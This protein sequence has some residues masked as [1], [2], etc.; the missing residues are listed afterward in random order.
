MYR[1]HL[2][3]DLR[4]SHVDTTVQLAG[5]VHRRRDHGGLVFIDLRDHSGLGQVV[6]HPEHPSFELA[7]TLR[8]EDVVRVDGTVRHRPEGTVND[9]LPSGAV[10]VEATALTVLNRSE[11]PPFEIDVE[12]PVHEDLRLEYRYLD[13]RHERLQ[14]NLA[15]RHR[16]VKRLRDLLDAKGF[17]EVETPSLVKGTPEGSREFLVPSR[18]HPGKFYVLPQSPQQFKQLLMVGGV[19]KYF[20]I[21]RCYR[22]EDQRGDR[23]PEFTQLDLEVAFTDDEEIMQLTEELLIDLTRAVVPGK[24]IQTVPFPR[25][26]WAEAMGRYGTD[27]PDLRFEM[28]FTDVSDWAADCG[29]K[30]FTDVAAAGGIVKALRVAGGGAMSRTQIDKLTEVAKAAGAKGL[31]YVVL[32]ADGTGPLAKNLTPEAVAALRKI[33]GAEDGDLLLFGAGR[34]LGEAVT[35]LGA[36]RLAVAEQQGL[37][38]KDALSYVWVTNFPLFE[39]GDD[40]SIGAGHHP[41]TCPM[42]A[43][44][45]R[46]ETDPLSVGS[47]TYDIVLN[48]VEVGGGSIRIHDRELQARVFRALKIDEAAQERRF[49]HMLRAFTYGAP[50]HGGIAWGVD[51]IVML[52]LD[53]PNIREVIA[54]PKNQRAQDLLMGAPS[55]LPAKDVAE[56]HIRVIEEE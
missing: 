28:A 45:D 55:E 52:F 15:V 46:L 18:L 36:V 14:R 13:L 32:G 23:Q 54:F 40:G 41:F 11:T 12:K 4:A 42:E 17:L 33:S 49:G 37:L 39:I 21:A 29:F 56:M 8:P 6:F 30:I 5:W 3:G 10:E 51:R 20:Q 48:G 26:T 47:H 44:L 53:E 43:D 9:K 24:R 19:P 2:A 1:T 7:G 50:P 22:D 31:A 16:F 25:L 38:D 35:G 34:K 27:K